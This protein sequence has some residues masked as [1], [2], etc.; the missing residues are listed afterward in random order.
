MTRPRIQSTELAARSFRRQLPNLT[1]A[2]LAAGLSFGSGDD[3][4]GKRWICPLTVRRCLGAISNR[5][6]SASLMHNNV[7]CSS[8]RILLSRVIV[9]LYS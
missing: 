7:H 8:Y 2:H 3:T 6:P 1:N 5:R 9:L 4:V